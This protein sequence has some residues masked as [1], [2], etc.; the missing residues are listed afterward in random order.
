MES[1]A[2]E[3][4]LKA[5]NLDPTNEVAHLGLGHVKFDGKWMQPEEAN[6]AKG[7]VK[8]DDAWVTQ[9]AKQD[10]VKINAQ[11]ELQEKTMELERLKIELA[12]AEAEKAQAEADRARA[13]NENE[14][15][16]RNSY[17]VV[18]PYFQGYAPAPPVR[19]TPNPPVTYS[20]DANGNTQKYIG[21]SVPNTI[22]TPNGPVTVP[23]SNRPWDG[24]PT[25][26]V[27]PPAT[28]TPEK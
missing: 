22:Y 23:P 13:Q 8:H 28:V 1:Q 10:L 11:K 18:D 26:T 14:R 17:I 19:V 12:R 21:G 4:F 2:G 16:R 7:L 20:K 15:V 9:E 3:C 25:V 27:H 6:K 24:Q 5:I